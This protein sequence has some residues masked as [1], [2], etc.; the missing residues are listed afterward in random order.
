[1]VVAR[2]GNRISITGAVPADETYSVTYQVTVRADAER[3]DDIAANFLLPNDPDNPPAPPTDPVCQPTDG[4]RPDC[5]VTPIGRL[6]TGKAVAADSDPVVAG[7]V[8]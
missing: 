3:G 4:G 5:T 2:D 8:L 6:L 7:T 1:L